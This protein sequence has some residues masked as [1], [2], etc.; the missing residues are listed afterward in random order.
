MSRVT[1]EQLKETVSRLEKE[2]PNCN[3]VI[4]FSNLVTNR[5]FNK[6]IRM[7][8]FGA[9]N[10]ILSRF[11]PITEIGQHLL[12]TGFKLD[13]NMIES[14]QLTLKYF[15]HCNNLLN[16]LGTDYFIHKYYELRLPD[17]P[18]RYDECK[19][20]T[21]DRIELIKTLFN[22]STL[23]G[24]VDITVRHGAPSIDIKFFEKS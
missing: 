19:L 14:H 9:C 7:Y 5:L 8:A 21:N 10:K 4:N 3:D 20:S 24:K 18:S 22:K 2:Y 13:F 16:V 12:Q 6:T 11:V 15:H 1:I 23:N 17:I